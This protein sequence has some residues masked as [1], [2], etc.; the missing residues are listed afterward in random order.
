MQ[1]E[2]HNNQNTDR[3]ADLYSQ[4]HIANETDANYYEELESQLVRPQGFTKEQRL[5]FLLRDQRCIFQYPP[6]ISLCQE[7][8]LSYRH[9]CS[10]ELHCHHIEP[11]TFLAYLGFDELY[12]NRAENG[13]LVCKY[14]HLNWI[15]PD[16]GKAMRNYRKNLDGI[17]EVFEN[18]SNLLKK[19]KKYWIDLWDDLFYAISLHNTSQFVLSGGPK[20][21]IAK[22]S[23]PSNGNSFKNGR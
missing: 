16:I 13:I 3:L 14:V 11:K 4:L 17:R 1:T 22:R 20:Y 23:Y 7:R 9:K 5:W 10:E 2:R 18:R 15:H 12:I 21:P 6:F 8:G 19:G